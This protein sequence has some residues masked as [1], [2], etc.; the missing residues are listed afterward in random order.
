M[1]AEAPGIETIFYGVEKLIKKKGINDDGE[2][3]EFYIKPV[4]FGK[5]MKG[6]SVHDS[7]NLLVRREVRAFQNQL[8]KVAMYWNEHN[9]Y[10]TID[11]N[12][13]TY[14]WKCEE[15]GGSSTT[16]LRFSPIEVE[17]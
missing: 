13:S 12:G 8:L 2:V 15:V 10:G 1:T 6:L 3:K 9:T 5:M 14:R 17:K 16:K 4:P 11:L 7:H